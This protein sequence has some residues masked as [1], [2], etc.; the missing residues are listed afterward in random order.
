MLTLNFP[1]FSTPSTTP[2][3]P[4]PS[5]L[6]LTQ[7]A[8]DCNTGQLTLNTS[9]GNGAPIE[10]R[11]IGNRD[12]S[13]SSTFTIPAH[14]R[15]GTTFTLDARQSGQ[16]ISI[17][18]TSVCGT[19]TT[20]QPPNPPTTPSGFVLQT[21][22]FNCATGLLSAAFSNGNGGPVEYRIVGN[23]DWNSSNEFVIPPWQRNGTTFTI[24]GRLNNGA[25][26]SIQFTTNCGAA[27]T[28]NAE[29]MAIPQL[30]AQLLPN[31]V[32]GNE[33]VVEVTGANGQA[34][35]FA[36]S[37]LSGKVLNIQRAEAVSDRHRQT[38]AVGNLIEGVYLLRVSTATQHKTL[39]VL[40]R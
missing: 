35:D 12:W 39:K 4:T 37:D 28:A 34:V 36:L 18:F 14:Q 5:G 10:F 38:M 21:P 7:P 2:P 23:R 32:T 13:A 17:G 8:Y 24:D 29:T 33:L 9:G 3:S 31:P 26:S 25:T 30:N 15:Q 11:I 6:V 1:S 27:R 22:N 40:K 19:S 20:P 16:V